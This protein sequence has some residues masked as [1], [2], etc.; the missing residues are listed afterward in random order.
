VADDGEPRIETAS[1]HGRTIWRAQVT[2]LTSAE[3]QGACAALAR[4]RAACV[5]LRP[6]PR[7]VASR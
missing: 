6:D 1:Q 2:G 4:H 3:A 5:I 7:Q